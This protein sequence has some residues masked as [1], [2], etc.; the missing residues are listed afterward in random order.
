[1]EKYFDLVGVGSMVVDLIYRTPRLISGEEKIKLR[2][3]DAGGETVRMLVGGVALNHLSWASLLGL[4]VGICG[5]QGDDEYGRFLRAGMDRYRI[6][7]HITLDGSASSSAHIFVDPEGRR[8]IYMSP[9]ATSETT[10]EYLRTRHAD[11]IR[12]SRMLSTEIS[13]LP[14]DAVVAALEIAREAGATTVLDVDIPRGDAIRTLG[15]ADD[16]ERALQLADYLKPS[17]AAVS[18]MINEDDALRAARIL[19]EKY[20]SRAVVI[21][22]GD[23]GCAIASDELVDRAPAY[24][25]KTIDSTGA[26]DAFL[27]GMTAGLNYGLK[28]EDTLKLAN[29]CG[30]A[31]SEILGATPDLSESRARVFELYDGARFDAIVFEAASSV[32][33]DSSIS[34]YQNAVPIFL[35]IAIEELGKLRAKIGDE[36]YFKRAA[37]LIER[38]ESRG[39]RIHVTG[40]GKPEYVAGY[41]AALLSSTGAPAY[42]LHGTECV[43]GSAGQVVPG[44]LVIAISNSGETVEMKAAIAA[45]RRNGALVLGV[46]GNPDSWLGR[47]SDEFLYAGVEREGSPLNFEPRASILAEI[48]TLAALSIEL[49]SRKNITRTH[50]NS[51]HPGGTIGTV[52]AEHEVDL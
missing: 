44:D 18:E 37:D 39:G 7:K 38:I 13:Q 24:Q 51:W 32:T 16:F 41:V 22:D 45:L 28:W 52:T 49:Q 42:F 35:D 17:K 8:G 3:H 43:H 40:I 1:M 21:T 15:S 20:G 11:Y 9:A 34:P 12:R 30:A 26:G 10:G 46:S 6:D 14:L 31:C 25:I 27:G 33:P 19:R 47:V 36:N 23:A 5:K 50:Y 29:A 4:R 2:Q 48:Y